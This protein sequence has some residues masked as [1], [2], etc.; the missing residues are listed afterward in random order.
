MELVWRKIFSRVAQQCGQAEGRINSQSH[1][2]K[3]GATSDRA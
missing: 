3:L 2:E 1:H